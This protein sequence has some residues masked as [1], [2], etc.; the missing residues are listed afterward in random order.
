MLQLGGN[1]RVGV[2]YRPAPPSP[3]LQLHPVTCTPARLHASSERGEVRTKGQLSGTQ[4]G[5]VKLSRVRWGGGAGDMMPHLQ[6]NTVSTDRCLADRRSLTH[7]INIGPGA[8]VIQ[9]LGGNNSEYITGREVRQT[10][11]TSSE[12]EQ[13]VPA[14]LIRP[15]L[16]FSHSLLQLNKMAPTCLLFVCCQ[17]SKVLKRHSLARPGAGIHKS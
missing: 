10:T 8:A 12:R 1:D 3:G 17:N 4:S 6:N 5:R 11:Q 7:R 13:P 15:H 16:V 9:S 2:L 14:L